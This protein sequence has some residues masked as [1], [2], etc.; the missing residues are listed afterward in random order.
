MKTHIIKAILLSSIVL[1]GGCNNGLNNNSQS[2]P[3][4]DGG[5][6]PASSIQRNV[7]SS[8]IDSLIVERGQPEELNKYDSGNYHSHSYWYWTKGYQKEFTWGGYVNGCEV[9]TYTFD[10]IR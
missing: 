1:F 5:T 9:S 2:Q 3:P 4:S 10:P 6:S 7:C 8:A